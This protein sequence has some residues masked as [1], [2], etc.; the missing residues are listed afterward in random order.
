MVS[1]LEECKELSSLIIKW[2]RHFHQ[3]P[4]LGFNEVK[5]AEF[6]ANLLEEFGL[7]VKK[8]VGKTGVVGLLGEGKP[9]IAL[10]ADMD[11]LPIQDIKSVEYASKVPGIMHA[12]GHDAHV[13]MLLGVAK[14]L[15][16]KEYLPRGSIKF[17]FQPFEEG[18]DKDGIGGA[19]AMLEDHVL[20]GVDAIIGQHVNAEL[21]AGVFQIKTGYFSAAVDTF[22]GE[23]IG[24]GCH[25]AYPHLGIDPVFISAQIINAVQAVISRKVDPLEP[26]VI[27]FGTIQAGTAANIIPSKVELTGTIRSL[28]PS[29]RAQ[30]KKELERVFQLS[31]NFGGNYRL[32]ITEG[33]PSM[34]NND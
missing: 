22:S 28:N 26:A 23:V 30:L 20:D 17:I 2:R 4:E 5:T 31:R 19:D 7:K 10:R 15:A 13:A 32:K 6:V 24:K 33:Y 8:K 16:N 34:D 25:G 12:C 9:C 11:A 18:Q 1:L 14:L 27:S 21:E 3:F 29:V